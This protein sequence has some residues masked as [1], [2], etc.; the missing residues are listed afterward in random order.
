[1]INLKGEKFGRLTVLKKTSKPKTTN[2]KELFWL[3]S[4]SCGK[5][6]VVN[7]YALRIG[8]TK[9]CGCFLRDS[10]FTHSITHG[11]SKSTEYKT[12]WNIKNRCYNKNVP[13]YYL[14]GGR[15]IRMSKSWYHSFEQF[16]KDMGKVPEGKSIERLNN[17][18]GY[19]K[20]NCIW[21]TREEQNNN[22]RNNIKV[23]YKGKKYTI[24]QLARKVGLK[25]H[26]VYTRFKK[27][28]TVDQCVASIKGVSKCE[29]RISSIKK[30]KKGT[31][32]ENHV[33]SIECESE[34]GKVKF[35]V[36][37]LTDA[38]HLKDWD[39]WLTLLGSV[40]SVEYDGL[41]KDKSKDVWSLYLP[42]NLICRPDRDMADTLEMLQNR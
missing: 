20:K 19:T 21:A 27:G 11:K 35:S 37:G 13:H 4:C 34:C 9:S 15:G 30:G 2:S 24:A 32:W 33:G 1:M 18:K 12:Y 38:E 26:T 16:L 22:K 28:K 36:G 8:R 39:E 25:Y 29:F 5:E 40:V 42:R 3:C 31:K 17:S 14:Y 41:I 7:G 10:R 6:T 23:E